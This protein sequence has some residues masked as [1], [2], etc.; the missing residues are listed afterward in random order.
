LSTPYLCLLR[1]SDAAEVKK[2]L[3]YLIKIGKP[4][5]GLDPDS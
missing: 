1:F 2:I 5:P 3:R 4:P